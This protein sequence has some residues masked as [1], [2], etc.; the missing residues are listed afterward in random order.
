MLSILLLTAFTVSIDSFLCGFSISI[1]KKNKYLIVPIIALTVFLMC[2]IANYFGILL[3]GVLTERTAGLSGII[4]VIVGLYNLFKKDDGEKSHSSVLQSF[5]SGFA[6]GVDGSLA[7]LSLSLMGINA[8][9]VPI[10]IALFHAI[11]IA[12]GIFLSDKIFTKKLK[13]L[14]FIAPLIL[15]G[16]GVYKTLSVFI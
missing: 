14:K 15:I 12:L 9:Y 2:L 6:V 5:I 8:F 4:L 10:T 3:T 7:N 16:L 11:L 13:N 1:D